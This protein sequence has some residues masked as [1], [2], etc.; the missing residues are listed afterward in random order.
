MELWNIEKNKKSFPSFHYSNI[1]FKTF[2]CER[3]RNVVT[4]LIIIAL[5]L[6]ITGIIGCI[7]PGLPGVPLNFI[8]MLMI[9][10]AFQPYNTVTL[11]IF[12]V[13][14]VIVTVLDYMIPIW[15]AKRFGATKWGIW[16]SVIGMIAGIFFTPVGMILGTLLGAI[17]GDLIAGRT[18]TQATRAGLGSLFG[19]LATMG[20]KLMLAGGM[21]FSVVYKII[22]FSFGDASGDDGCG[23]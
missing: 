5:L 21:T 8:A 20:I 7:V 18:A 6:C 12:G 23:G 10:W 15:T 19:T 11:I 4:T 1:P 9:H 17:I 3:I 14:T 16:G 22:K 2:L 13:L